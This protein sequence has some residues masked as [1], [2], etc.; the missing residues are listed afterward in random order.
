[1]VPDPHHV[2]GTW[3]IPLTMQLAQRSSESRS[4]IPTAVPFV[5]NNLTEHSRA[6]AGGP[7][8]LPRRR[9]LPLGLPPAGLASLPG[10]T[11]LVLA[12]GA[13]SPSTPLPRR[14]PPRP[15]AWSRAGS[16]GGAR[17]PARRLA[18][19]RGRPWG[20]PARGR[21]PRPPP[22]PGRRRA[23]PARGRG[24]RPCRRLA[25]E[26]CQHPRLGTRHDTPARPPTFVRNDTAPQPGKL[27]FPQ[28]SLCA[29]H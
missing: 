3:T 23:R 7:G 18:G 12:R 29:T 9:A 21:G 13:P 2:S 28:T 14:T 16:R 11:C 20:A 8:V 22:P 4:K 15:A 10:H 5:Q 1:M 25:P 19:A 6:G 27:R 26:G 17:R 24:R